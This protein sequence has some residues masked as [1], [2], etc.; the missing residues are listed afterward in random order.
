AELVALH[1]GTVQVTSE[2][3]RGSAFT[4]RI[5]TGSAHLPA[6]RID[7]ERRED[8]GRLRHSYVEEALRWLPDTP[9]VATSD[10]PDHAVVRVADDNADMRAHL[11][12][13]LGRHWTVRLAPDGQTALRMART[14]PPDV[15]VA[16]VMMPGLDGFSLLRELRA[17]PRTSELPVI[18]LTARAGRE[19]VVEGLEAGADDY[20]VKPFTTAELVARVHTHLRTARVRQRATLRMRSLANASHALSTSLDVGE[21]VDVLTTLVVPQWADEC[22]VWLREQTRTGEWRLVART[23]RERDGEITGQVRTDPDTAAEAVGVARALGAGRPHQARLSGGVLALTLPL[24]ARG[25][26]LGALTVARRG[27]APWRPTDLE[28]LTDLARRLALA[29]DNAARYEA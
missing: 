18:M 20:L 17:D 3:G 4:V 24:R 19:S 7:G 5:P 9:S 16:D 22:V 6:D 23:C 10:P 1:G 29:L 12:R 13:A 14:S 15:V 27:G 26:Q 8:A 11:R 28:Y 2:P 21:I 25:D